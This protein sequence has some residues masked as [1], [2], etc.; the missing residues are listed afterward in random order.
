MLVIGGLFGTGIFFYIRH[1]ETDAKI[2][3]TIE[4]ELKRAGAEIW[5]NGTS[6]TLFANT[7]ES[8]KDLEDL[9]RVV[10]AV[11][12]DV[13]GAEP[14]ITV[15]E[16]DPG[17]DIGSHQII[18]RIRSKTVL[19]VRAR[20]DKPTGL[21]KFI[22]EKNGINASRKDQKTPVTISDRLDPGALVPVPATAPPGANPAA[23]P[24][25]VPAAGT[26]PAEKVSEHP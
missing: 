8:R 12:A 11:R 3:D 18:Y 24:P 22:E 2:G 16:V 4:E 15:A 23:P 1:A 13:K 25:A 7:D 10:M 19:M 14:E 20:Y 5:T 6:P 26:P 17:R 9:P 21:F